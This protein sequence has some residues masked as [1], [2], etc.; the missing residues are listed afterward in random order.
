MVRVCRRQV[1]VAAGGLLIAPIRA[2]AQRYTKLRKIA[3]LASDGPLASDCTVTPPSAT[4]SALLKGLEEFGY[5]DGQTVVLACRSARGRYEDL[6]VLAAEL[7][8][9]QPA[10]II[11]AAAPASIAAKRATSAIPIVSVYTADPVGL[12]LVSSLARPGGNVTGISALASDYVAKSL[13]LLKELAPRTSCVGVLGHRPNPTFGIYW[14]K[15]EGAAKVLRLRLEF[16][17]VDTVADIEG[18]AQQM[19]ARGVDGFLVMH[20][21]FTYD[22]RADFVGALAIHRLPTMFG[23]KEAVELGGLASYAVGVPAVFKRSAYFVDKILKGTKP[24]DLPVE[25]P[26]SFELALNL[27]T[28]KEIGLPIPQSLLIRADRVIE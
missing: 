22:R 12:G 20:Q 26:T 2:W 3:V 27:K 1:L 9:L 17:A 23:S 4:W 15:L 11:A 24:A 7:A 13:Q 16:G 19:R 21:P 5:R 28:A 18:V 8:K 14:A 10:V 6:D 25:Q